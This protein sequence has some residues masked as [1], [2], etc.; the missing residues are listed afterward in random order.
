MIPAK[1]EKI[2]SA[3]EVGTSITRELYFISFVIL[4]YNVYFLN[5]IRVQSLY[6]IF[7]LGKQQKIFSDYFLV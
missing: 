3:I 6:E 1:E 7:D 2:D 4:F 5:K